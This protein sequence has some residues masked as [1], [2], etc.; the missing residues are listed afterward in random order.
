MIVVVVVIVWGL[1]SD[2]GVIAIVVICLSFLQCF[3]IFVINLVL[4]ILC[5][6]PTERVRFV[7]IG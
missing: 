5:L 1:C 6:S 7:R 3:A 2:G 4:S